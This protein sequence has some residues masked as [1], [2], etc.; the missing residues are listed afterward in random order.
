MELAGL[1]LGWIFLLHTHTLVRRTFQRPELPNGN[2]TLHL[3]GE[4]ADDEAKLSKK[5]YATIFPCVDPP[6]HS[7]S[8]VFHRN[9]PSRDMLYYVAYVYNG[10]L[11]SLI[12]NQRF[13]K[14]F[15]PKSKILFVLSLALIRCQNFQDRISPVGGDHVVEPSAE[16]STTIYICE[17]V[18]QA[19]RM[20]KFLNKRAGPSR[21]SPVTFKRHFFDVTT[22]SELTRKSAD[23]QTTCFWRFQ[24]IWEAFS[25]KVAERSRD[26]GR[27]HATVGRLSNNVFS[28]VSSN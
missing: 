24:A 14:N 20:G 19:A 18:C 23:C 25:K 27:G 5:N 28:N 1:E 3:D 22:K 9:L 17:A 7:D 8:S 2:T 10:E 16:L 26:S 21:D 12:G 13:G 4:V 11:V 6:G 15:P